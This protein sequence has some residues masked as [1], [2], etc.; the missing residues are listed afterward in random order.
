MNEPSAPVLVC[1]LDALVGI[2]SPIIRSNSLSVH[3]LSWV[4]TRARATGFPAPSTITPEIEPPWV[5]RTM[6]PVT[7]LP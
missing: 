4:V 7:T 2:M 1:A 3:V 6:T 5:M